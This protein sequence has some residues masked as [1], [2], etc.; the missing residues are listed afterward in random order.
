MEMNLGDERGSMM[1]PAGPQMAAQAGKT[2]KTTMGRSIQMRGGCCHRI[3]PPLL[4]PYSCCV[5]HSTIGTYIQI[6]KNIVS[7][8]V[9]Y[10][11]GASN[12]CHYTNRFRPFQTR[13]TSDP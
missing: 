11:K 2:F 1:N 5:V 7:K 8:C 4:G 13:Q 12:P 6:I 9:Y 10:L 3:R